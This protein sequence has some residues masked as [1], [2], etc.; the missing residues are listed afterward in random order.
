MKGYARKGFAGIDKKDKVTLQVLIWV[1]TAAVA[2]YVFVMLL[3]FSHHDAGHVE[4]G[5][6][7]VEGHNYDMEGLLMEGFPSKPR[8]VT[9]AE[10][11]DDNAKEDKS[12]QEIKEALKEARLFTQESMLLK[13]EV[14]K[15]LRGSI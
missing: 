2:T 1:I 11:T 5:T 7:V 15:S 14:R 12:E 10:R 8:L 3:V 9:V 6:Q 13:R 4:G